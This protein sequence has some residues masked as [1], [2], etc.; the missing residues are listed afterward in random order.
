MARDKRM[1]IFED[2]FSAVL[3]VMNRWNNTLST[4]LRHA[5]DG[6]PLQVMTRQE[7]L[8]ATRAHVSIIAQTTQFDLERYLSL[9]DIFNGFGNRFLWA[10]AQRSKL[11][12]DG[13]GI[14]EE[15]VSALA[16][17]LRRKV[18]F[19]KRQ[20][21]I[22]LSVN[23]ACLWKRT[24]PKIS[25]DSPGQFGAVTSRAEAQVRRI[26]LIYALLDGSCKV[27]TA[28][29]H[30][31][32]EVWRFCEDSARFIFGGRSA[33][34]LEDK[35]LVILRRAETGMTRTQISRALQHHVASGVIAEALDLL[36]ERELVR[37]KSLKT[38]GRSAEV[39]R[40]STDK[41]RGV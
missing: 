30:A 23:A 11:L 17:K 1:M 32:L 40:A 39:W 35:I 12:P 19:A 38:K 31:A 28:H 41:E 36:R 24:Y 37:K 25:A 15:Q 13:G 20:K 2:E 8:R 33:A 34:T 7:P 18:Q 10:C 26:A 4:T 5:W 29:L 3:R 14:R 22:G 21:R 6:R 27:R 16:K 9:T